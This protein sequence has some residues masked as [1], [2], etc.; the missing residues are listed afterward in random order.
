MI[1][2]EIELL[3]QPK[4]L[5]ACNVKVEKSANC[6]AYRDTYLELCVIEEG[7]LR[8][9]EFDGTEE[10]LGPGMLTTIA[11]DSG[12]RT[13]SLEGQRHCHTTV[14]VIAD[15]RCRRMDSET[16]PDCNGW[17]EKI[18]NGNVFLVPYRWKIDEIYYKA[19]QLI[20][21]MSR[22]HNSQSPAAPLETV[23]KW[24]ALAGLFTGYVLR[25]LETA[26]VSVSASE[27]RCARNAVEYIENNYNKRL[28]VDEIARV[29]Q[30]SKGYLHRIFKKVY[31]MGIT[32]YIN[33]HRVVV[34]LSL[35]DKRRLSLKEAAYNVGID[36]PAYMSRLFKKVTGTSYR[37]YEKKRIDL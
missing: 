33:R 26:Q 32:E 12:V 35:M 17:R 20:T 8:H 18:K 10:I 11:K 36:D 31:G 3:S 16:V 14:G 25:Q 28:Q 30:I 7:Y 6:F 9:T 1:F 22:L 13:A 34:A 2:Y 37:N 21:E 5:L 19:I 15:Y 29:L 27:Q 24:Y 23:G 4:I